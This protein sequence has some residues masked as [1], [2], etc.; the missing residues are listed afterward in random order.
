MTNKLVA[1]CLEEFGK[2]LEATFDLVVFKD[3]RSIEGCIVLRGT[4][5][6]GNIDDFAVLENTDDFVVFRGSESVYGFVVLESSV[7]EAFKVTKDDTGGF[8]T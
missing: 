4:D 6:D 8:V 7:F 3:V 5:N 1:G 2:I